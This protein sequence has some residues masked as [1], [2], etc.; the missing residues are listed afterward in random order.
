[1]YSC[2]IITSDMQSKMWGEPDL[3]AGTAVDLEMM[4]ST[5]P[6]QPGVDLLQTQQRSFTNNLAD[7]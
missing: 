7:S 2:T 1:M 3:T 5:E 6:Y 4:H